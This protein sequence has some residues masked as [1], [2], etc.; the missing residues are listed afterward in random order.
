MFPHLAGRP[1]FPLSAG[2]DY[3]TRWGGR[4]TTHRGMPVGAESMDM[5]LKVMIADHACHRTRGNLCHQIPRAQS[6][7]SADHT[8]CRNAGTSPNGHRWA[9]RPDSPPATETG[10]MRGRYSSKDAE[11]GHGCRTKPRAATSLHPASEPTRSA[12][13]RAVDHTNARPTSPPAATNANATQISQIKAS[14][15]DRIARPKTPAPAQAARM[16]PA[17]LPVSPVARHRGCRPPCSA[18]A[19]PGYCPEATRPLSSC[20][21]YAG[22]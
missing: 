10:S 2:P 16:R 14:H 9:R 21:K 20:Q 17:I 5:D 19:A 1:R 13:G 12:S 4:G 22:G 15:P 6:P 18:A 11:P 7:V 3:R 8:E